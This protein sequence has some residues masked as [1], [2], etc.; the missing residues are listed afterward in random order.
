MNLFAKNLTNENS[1]QTINFANNSSSITNFM[2]RSR[3]ILLKFGFK[4]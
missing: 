3:H 1:L 4:F 2:L